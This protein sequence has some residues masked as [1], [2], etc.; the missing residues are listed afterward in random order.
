MPDQGVDIR[1]R[2]RGGRE[3]A[4]DSDRVAR[5]IG[6]IDSRARRGATGMRLF[7]RASASAG[8]GLRF[9]AGAALTGA[10]AIGGGLLF[11]LKRSTEAWQEKRKIIAQTGAV[12]RSTGGAANVTARDVDTLSNTLSRKTGMDD[13]AIASAENLLLTFRSVHNETGRGNDIF[14]Q[15]TRVTADLS[16]AMGMDLRSAALQVGKALND[17][18][19][20]FKRLQRIGVSFNKTQEDQI[21]RFSEAGDRASAQRVILR[22]LQRE[23]GGSAATQATALDRLKVSWGN[24]EEAV[25]R[26]ASPAVDLFAGKLDRAMVKAEPKIN[27]L[28]ERL[29]DLGKRKDLTTGQKLELGT[30]DVRRTTAPF[31]RAVRQ[32]IGTMNLGDKLG[33][34]VEAAAPRAA[35]AAGRA[36]PRVAGAFVNAWINAGPWGK[37]FTLGLLAKKLGVFTL[38]GRSAAVRFG[39]G[40]GAGPALPVM[41]GGPGGGGPGGKAGRLARLGNAAGKIPAIGTAGL[42]GWEVGSALHD[43]AVG[44]KARG[45]IGN[46]PGAIRRRNQDKMRDRGLVPVHLPNGAVVW[47]KPADARR[48]RA[49]ART[50]RAHTS[51]VIHTHVHVDKREIARAT[52]RV[53]DNERAHNRRP[54]K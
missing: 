27:A 44:R 10:A 26:G 47:E 20:G 12:L 51:T 35:D 37:L 45:L 38:L 30:A 48:E 11:E 28:G 14:N 4:R 21:K 2:V 39:M 25:G 43:T 13:E 29:G 23:F 16:A 7:G 18:E 31:V 40:W 1:L 53:N 19:R 15:A 22:E 41:P 24:V 33:D 6:R 46:D 54:P 49:R 34:A 3:A 52:N 32:E 5:S 9:T 17:P 8:R 36:A 42:V 50:P